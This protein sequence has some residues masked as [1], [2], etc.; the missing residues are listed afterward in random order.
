MDA[1]TRST[2]FS[3]GVDVGGTFTD[4]VAFDHASRRIAVAKVPSDPENQA[5]GFMTALAK[6]ETRLRDVRRVLHGTTVAT[7]AILEGKGCRVALLTTAGFRDVIEIG[8]GERSK[9]YDLKLVKP[10]ALVPRPARFEVDERTR[11]DGTIARPVNADD[12]RAALASIDPK[13]FDAWAICFL[14]AYANPANEQAAMGCLEALVGHVPITIS[15]A[16]TPEYREYE[17]FSTTVLNALVAPLMNRYLEAVEIRLAAGGYTHPLLVMHSSG[18]VMTARG[19]RQI[20][21]ATIL[22]GP[23]GGVAGAAA[24]AARA[25]LHNVIT[26]DMGG[27]STD[28]TLIQ[29][30]TIRHTTEGRIA[31]YPT[32]IPQVDIVT[33]GAGGGSIADIIGGTLQVGPASAGAQ[34]GPA[35]YGQG[36]EAATVT[37]A[38]L[39]LNRLNGTD[40]LSGE[41]TLHPE[42][43]RAAID[44]LGTGLEDLDTIAVAE[45]I[46]HL[47]TVKMA[48]TIRE[49]SVYRGHDPRDFVLLAYGGAG[50][51]FASELASELGIRS[52]LI[53]P[54]P[55]NLSALGLLASPLKR[56]FVRTLVRQLETME[57]VE[58]TEVYQDLQ[59]QSLAEFAADHLA[60]EDLAFE[61]SVDVRYVG[62]SSTLNLAIPSDAPEPAALVTAFHAAHEA[63]FG[64]SASDEPVE[65]VNVRMSAVL[66]IDPLDLRVEAP[67][68][69]AAGPAG[70]RPVHFRG[71]RFDC[72]FYDRD[73]LAL[74]T[75]LDGPLIVEELG[76]TTV[77]WPTDRVHVDDHGNLRLEVGEK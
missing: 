77:V 26:C 25:D 48:G 19:A 16:V 74:G 58:L 68:S 47:A 11:P 57:A 56:D 4:V 60:G 33:V 63:A 54:H 52:V 69:G 62:Q 70:S 31:G 65:L 20:P 12:V 42:L 14:H 61:R 75:R 18:G 76:S 64:H 66:P 28:V 53:P 8:R 7:N 24:I 32:R 2:S 40:P 9:L 71:R 6:V 30:G 59:T 1:R 15:S 50:P 39:V 73:T 27:T 17:R 38:S 44:R 45:G 72:P 22:S 35:C 46:A 23:A 43:A 29:N 55:G 37:D 36:G 10:P 51:M 41:I 67:A 49:V 13:T 21:A 5:T 3:V 34:P